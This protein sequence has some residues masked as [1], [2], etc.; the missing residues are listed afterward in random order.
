MTDGNASNAGG[1]VLEGPIAELRERE[2]R[3][4]YDLAE[5]VGNMGGEGGAGDRQR[6]LDTASDLREMFLM[7]VV[8]GEF[9]AGKSTFVNALLGDSLLPTGI[10]P[11]TD[12]IELVRYAPSKMR[13]P[14]LRDD[15]IREW[16]HPNTGAPGVV[17]VD[18]PGTGSVF[19]KHEQLAKSFLHRSD[20]VIF[21]IS[22]KRAFA[23]TERLY[24]ELAK[25]YGKK[26]IV[27]IN[28]SDLLDPKEQAEV[29]GFVQQQIDEL[30]DLRPPI[31]LVSAK[32]ALQG[33]RSSGGLL[34]G[35]V[36]SGGKADYGI[37]AVRAYL[38]QTFEQVP[39][40]KQKLLTQLDLLRNVSAKYRKA[41]RAKLS[42]IGNDTNAA[43]NLQREIEQQ[44]A[45]LDKQLDGTVQEMQTIFDGVRQRGEDFIASHLNVLRAT[46]RGL[47]KEALRTEFETDVIGKA[48][49]QISG[50][51]EQYVNAVIDGG[52][53]YWRTVI[54]RLNKM[55]ALLRE[56]AASMDAAA[57][58]DQRKALQ[59]AMTM[60]DVEM[61]SYSDNRV[62]EGIQSSFEQNVRG[63]AYG[64]V[65]G[66]GGVLAVIISLVTPGALAVHP[67]AALGF[68]VGLPVMLI[69]GGAAYAF[70]RKAV[71]D[72]RKQL[73]RSVQELEDTYQQSLV[74]LTSQER[75]RLLQYGK[76]ILS[77]VFS[78]LQTL[79]RRYKEQQAQLDTFQDRA[80]GLEAEINATSL[81]KPE[82][83]KA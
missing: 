30:L 14:D 32:K 45:A 29:K 60:A 15:A 82:K 46:R 42:L 73:N 21:V 3:L 20:L 77:P 24:L 34:S 35:L 76:Q 55:E 68:T 12:V 53:A 10:T 56:E 83:E 71:G 69:G 58:A 7:V 40:A 28:Q 27:V 8:I 18:T 50:I 33:D 2:V 65:S 25:D 19:Q 49:D 62:L 59:A 47:D 4:L 22:A 57:Y 38:R 9:N 64:A 23:E 31:F 44:A 80:K 41:I 78:Q 36:G 1:I 74:T 61:K 37:D 75:N 16:G 72:A 26:I 52:R 81:G 39:P 66:V 67:L 13:K 6:L 43:E 51:S 63:F 11:T 79:A 54:E 70:W 5:Y 17:I 48:L